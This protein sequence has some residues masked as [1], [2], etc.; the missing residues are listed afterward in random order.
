MSDGDNLVP[1]PPTSPSPS[2][3]V[4]SSLSS[5]DSDDILFDPEGED[6]Q[7]EIEHMRQEAEDISAAIVILQWVVDDWINNPDIDEEILAQ[8]LT[9]LQDLYNRYYHYLY[10]L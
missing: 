7:L 8:L 6:L 2:S 3:N 5:V 10:L 1:L 9:W 4:D